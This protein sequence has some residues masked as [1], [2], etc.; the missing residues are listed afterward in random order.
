MG[1]IRNVRTLIGA[2]AL[3]TAG[4]SAAFAVTSLLTPVS[5]APA[6]TDQLC[7]SV[8]VTGAVSKTVN[9]GCRNGGPLV[10]C[11]QHDGGFDPWIDVAAYLCV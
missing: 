7:E 10:V 2:S 11:E 4:T 3:A 1:K 8:T 9:L 5:A 6:A